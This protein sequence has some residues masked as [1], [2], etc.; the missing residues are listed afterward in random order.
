MAGQVSYFPP[1]NTHEAALYESLW[2]VANV[3]GSGNLQGS[4][5]VEFL[6][7]SG[8]EMPILKK[9]WS[10]STPVGTMNEDQFYI[11]LRL[12]SMAQN[13]VS[14][15]T[16]GS[17]ALLAVCWLNQIVGNRRKSCCFVGIGL[18]SPRI[19]GCSYPLHSLPA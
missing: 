17:D 4:K 9:I 1:P 15:L 14:T 16:K 10:L 18:R 11:A 3:D 8:L 19:R 5:A 7:K 6:K 2:H 13:G 12:I